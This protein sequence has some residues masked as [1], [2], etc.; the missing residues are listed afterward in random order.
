MKTIGNLELFTLES[1]EPVALTPLEERLHA[2]GYGLFPSAALDFP[3]ESIDFLKLLV[4]DP[5]TAFCRDSSTEI[6]LPHHWLVN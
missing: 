6:H 1:K 5:V 4:K 3:D 2:G